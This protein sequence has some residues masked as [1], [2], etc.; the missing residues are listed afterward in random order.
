[1]SITWEG[2]PYFVAGKEIAKSAIAI[3]PANPEANEKRVR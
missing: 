2:L 3:I 1:V